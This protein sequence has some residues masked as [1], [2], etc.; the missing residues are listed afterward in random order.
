MAEALND[1]ERELNMWQFDGNIASTEQELSLI[2]LEKTYSVSELIEFSI[3]VNDDSFNCGDLY[4][5]IYKTNPVNQVVTQSGYLKQCFTINQQNL[6][7]DEN[8]SV[9]ITESG[10]Y[11]TVIELSDEKHTQTLSYTET[12]IVR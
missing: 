4:I 6:P 2:G 11:K 1:S 10:T 12:F 5:T 3:K 8:Y 7:I 9:V